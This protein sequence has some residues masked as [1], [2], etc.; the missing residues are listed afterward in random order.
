MVHSSKGG[1]PAPSSPGEPV[2]AGGRP[3]DAVSAGGPDPERY[4][5]VTGDVNRPQLHATGRREAPEHD[6]VTVDRRRTHL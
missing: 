4:P 2:A 1:F 3:D 5:P 6:L